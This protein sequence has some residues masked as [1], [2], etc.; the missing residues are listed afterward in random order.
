MEYRVEDLA[1]RAGLSVDTIRFYQGRGLLPPPRRQGR[2]ALYSDAHL[3]RL[4]RVRTLL[5]Q[6][7][8]LALVKRLFE[9]E[10][11]GDRNLVE[12]L[13]DERV[14]ERSLTRPQLAAEAGVPE[15]LIA[16]AQAAG[17]V[18]PVEVDGEERFGEADLRMARSALAILEAGFPL[19]E[20]L[21]LAVRH[22]GEIQELCDRAIDLFDEH[23]RKGKVPGR[24]PGPAASNGDRSVTET[25]RELLPEATRLVALHFQRTLVSRALERLADRGEDEALRAALAA[26][27]S[28]RLEVA[29]R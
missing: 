23:V 11:A 5:D 14:G 16:A 22:A 29:W 13:V 12:A 21:A 15:P 6:G 17:L 4:R 8:T 20:I 27:E 1:A 19:Q 9:G 18:T 7:F 3:D 25:F 28:A 24:A 2:V 10:A 26:T